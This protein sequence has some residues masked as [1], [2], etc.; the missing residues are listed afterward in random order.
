MKNLTDFG[1]FVDLGDVDGLI[2]ISELAG[3]RVAHPSKVVSVGETITVK[4]IAVDI[5]RKRVSFSLR[6]VPK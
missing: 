5:E 4:V 6:A 2:H 3:H 1:A